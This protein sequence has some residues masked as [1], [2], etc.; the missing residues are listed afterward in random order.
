MTKI[1]ITGKD[2]YI[3]SSFET[4]AEDWTDYSVDTVDLID[5]S[6]RE[7]SFSGYDAVFH[8]A[9]IAHI[10]ETA[11]NAALY[12]SVNCDLAAETAEKAK[13][14]GV[15]QFVFL[16]SMSVYGKETGRITTDTVPCPKSHYG[17]SKLLA[18]EKLAALAD[19][20]F[21]ITVL[22]PP[23]VYGKGCKGN[24]NTLKSLALKLPFFPDVKNERSMIYIDN[25][26]AFVK[27][28]IDRCAGGVFFPQ[29]RT[30]CSTVA[31]AEM[32]ADS[33]GKKFRKSRL[34]GA[35][36]RF[37][38]CFLPV[39]QKGFGSLVYEGTETADFEYCVCEFPDSIRNSM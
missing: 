32:I 29:N 16:S 31:M 2:S 9:G 36:V 1:L 38:R 27:M 8:V 3:G 19:D 26:S 23:M 17:K 14:D 21:T 39:A 33:A 13:A 10:R 22:R 5:G 25:L 18:E 4:K 12:Y 6:W 7:R 24:F 35:G 37:L 20:D 15:R 30:Y 28:V 11:K 34:L